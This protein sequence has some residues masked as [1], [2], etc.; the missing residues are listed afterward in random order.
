MAV[1]GDGGVSLLADSEVVLWLCVGLG[2]SHYWQTVKWYYGC[3]WGWGCLTIGREGSGIM[4]VCGAGG[5]SLLADS[6]VVLWL[7]VGLGVSHYWQR[8]KW[9]YG[10]VWGWGCLTIGR[11]G[12]VIMAVCGAGGVSLLAERGSV[13]MAVCGAGG[14][15]LL[16]EREVV[17]WQCVGLGVSHYWQTV[18]WYYGC[19]W[20]W[21]CLTIAER[22]VVLW[23]CVGLGGCLTIGREGSGIM[24]VC[25]AGGVSLLADSEVGSWLHVLGWKCL[26][27]A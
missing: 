24:A 15:S 18:K 6:E 13:I 27:T 1:C 14:V 16:A 4:A 20:G 23:Q 19:V 26:T 12:S 11:E 21:G 3:V 8:G 10:S 17:L 9:Y 5:V 7:C 22:E 25:G 2:V